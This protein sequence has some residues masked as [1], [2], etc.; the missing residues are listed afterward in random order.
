MEFTLYHA[1]CCGQAKNTSYPQAVTVKNA[2]DL[3]GVVAYDHTCGEF[4]GF[5]RSKANFLSSDVEALDIDNDHSDEPEMWITPERF[6]EEFSDVDFIIV[7]SRN[8]N[9]V[10]DGKSARPRF[11]VFFPHKKMTELTEVE[12][13]K[14]AIHASFPFFDANCLDGARF[15]YGSTVKT[16]DIIW[17][18]GKMEINDYIRS[19]DAMT[20]TRY[21]IPQ[22][23]RNATMSKFAAKVVKR[24]GT[25]D[26]ARQIFMSEN[27]KCDPPLSDVELGKIWESAC[28][29]GKVIS[30]TPG[31]IPPDVYNGAQ[32]TDPGSLKPTD[33]S[34]IGQAKVLSA[35][36]GDELK[37]NGST[38][39]LH[40]NGVY[41]EESISAA[42]GATEQ[43]LDMQLADAEMVKFKA[44]QRC[45]NAGFTS[46]AL[47]GKKPPKDASSV[48]VKLFNEWLDACTYYAFVMKRRDMRYVKSAME[49]AKPMVYVDSKDLDKDPFLLNTPESTYD[50]R[51]GLMG[52][53][54]HDE[55]HLITKVTLVEPGDKGMDLW[56]ET[57][58]K[59]FC[60]D[61]ELIGYV[62]EVIGLAAIGKVFV[63]ALIIAFGD[64][65]NGKSTFF[66][67]ILRVLGSYG[68]SLSA[69]TLTV[70]CKRNTKWEITELKSRRLVIAA[71]LDEGQRLSTSILKQITSTDEIQGEK[72]FKDPAK[73]IPSHTCVLYTNHLPKVGASD[74]GTWRRLI[75]IPFT[76][77]F[78]NSGDTKN[79]A[80]YLINEAG[81][82]V[83]SWIIEGAERVIDKKFHLTRPQ[84][85]QDAIDEYRRDNDWLNI[86]ITECCIKDVNVRVKASDLYDDY[87]SYCE[88]VGEYTRSQA[89]LC[90]ALVAAGFDRKRMKNGWNF[91]G[92]RVRD[93][94][95]DD[96]D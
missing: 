43:F 68:G 2:D 62:Q 63:E 21:T 66:N 64:G 47:K 51:M 25:G 48:Q 86:Y 41:W 38:D 34:D 72:K 89:E 9:K 55:K 56:L 91:F 39:Y 70:G 5:K 23:Q 13:L 80:D 73:F 22:G 50:L 79:Y 18:E 83:L 35:E 29:F 45:L 59:T 30:Q 17:H 75:V 85:V 82:A 90:K 31:Y 92:L 53:M 67:T 24:F 1:N 26:G 11:H 40:Y 8:H 12:E 96:V 49:A 7:F 78:E 27:E 71:E 14:R 19:I 69:D 94:L 58:D 76:A 4:K 77:K 88:R 6:T 81:P 74:A 42:V 3:A 87:K 37:Y 84:C 95:L 28:K 16:E 46:D 93:D 60:G 36:Y 33:Y 44:K 54:A 20:N 10:K 57:L 65:R 32:V 61:S 15:L 52:K